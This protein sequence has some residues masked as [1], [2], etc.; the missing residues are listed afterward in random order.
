MNP[1]ASDNVALR[2]AMALG[3]PLIWFYG[4]G[5]A[6]FRALYP[7]WLVSEEP[8]QGQFVVALTE[9]LRAMQFLAS[10]PTSSWRSAPMSWKRRTVP[11]FCTRYR[12]F[13][14]PTFTC[15]EL[16]RPGRGRTC[17]KSGTS[18]SGPQA[19]PALENEPIL[20]RPRP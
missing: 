11:H 2:R 18:A 17:S 9:D 14:T 5:P 1:E 13:T 7:V 16:G 20:G 15:R 4:V 6:V 10:G 19:S 3:K 8:D 12:D